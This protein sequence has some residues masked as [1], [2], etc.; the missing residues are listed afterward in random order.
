MPLTLEN[1]NGRI[2]AVDDQG[3]E[4]PIQL[5][6]TVH[7]SVNTDEQATDV[8]YP[9]DDQRLTGRDF[10]KLSEI[11]YGEEQQTRPIL[12]ITYDDESQSVYN[13]AFPVHQDEGVPG[14][15]YIHSGNVGETSNWGD[16]VT[17][18]QIREMHNTAPDNGGIGAGDHT[19]TGTDQSNKTQDELVADAKTSLQNFQD[20]GV[21][22]VK[23]HAYPF[24]NNDA[25]ARNVMQRFFVSA[26][27]T[28]GG[29]ENHTVHPF[30]IT[31]NGIDSES[32]STVKSEIDTA[33]S[34]NEWYPILMH[35]VHPDGTLDGN[36]VQTPSN[37]QEIIQYAKNQGMDV[38]TVDNA[39]A[40]F[41]PRYFHQARDG[42]KTLNVRRDGKAEMAVA[43]PTQA[44]DATGL[45]HGTPSG[46]ARWASWGSGS[47]QTAAQTAEAVITSDGTLQD[48]IDTGNS[49]S[50]AFV[51]TAEKRGTLAGI[52]D[53]VLVS[54]HNTIEKVHYVGRSTTD[55]SSYG[56]DGTM[57]QMSINDDGTDYDVGVHQL[58]GG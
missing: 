19:P 35:G 24:G 2:V 17:L 29:Y 21:Y 18:D 56:N 5:G 47:S 30:K 41:A 13:H 43:K 6:D 31:C 32:V 34:N 9:G 48:L 22:P 12:T 51:V 14:L 54:I 11:G 37:L 7:D 45:N 50:G 44:M 58:G 57:I 39:L 15:F 20:E 53:L 49:P 26:R 28:G 46:P 27:A 42:T 10:T 3:N 8:H 4:Q 33:V 40:T 38:V 52:T 36:T 16:P 55:I 1:R 23:H 25:L